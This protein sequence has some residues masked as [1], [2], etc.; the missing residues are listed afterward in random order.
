[1]SRGRSSPE[2][3]GRGGVAL[4]STLQFALGL[5]GGTG[6]RQQVRRRHAAEFMVYVLWVMVA[7][8]W[9]R[10]ARCCVIFVFATSRR[11]SMHRR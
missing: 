8:G 3:A 2:R 4:L 9:V 1:M 6:Y 10:I 5:A 7:C 11:E